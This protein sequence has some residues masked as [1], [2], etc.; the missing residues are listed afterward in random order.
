METPVSFTS[1]RP[2][3]IGYRIGFVAQFARPRAPHADYTRLLVGSTVF[4]W[5][6]IHCWHLPFE[7]AS[8]LRWGAALAQS[9]SPPLFMTGLYIFVTG[10]PSW[11]RVPGGRA[12]GATLIFLSIATVFGS[13]ILAMLPVGVH[14]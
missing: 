12:S 3:H 8:A 11:L 6:L 5:V 2:P 14:L 7:Q 13:A 1:V 4:L 9:I 10:R